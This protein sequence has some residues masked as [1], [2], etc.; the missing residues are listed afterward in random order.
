MTSDSQAFRVSESSTGRL[1]VSGEMTIYTA[2]AL[3]EELQE[4]LATQ[5]R[6][7]VL[8][9]SQVRE[10][11]TAGLQLLLCAQREAAAAG[12][13]LAVID[14]S[15]A[16]RDVLELYQLQWLTA[17]NATPGAPKATR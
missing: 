7:V 10:F 2:S 17:P 13:E 3:N 9:L 8:D 16:V 5:P 1:S 12:R 11:D 14:P 15:G 4:M 6:G